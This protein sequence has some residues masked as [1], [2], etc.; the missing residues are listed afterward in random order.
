MRQPFLLSLIQS[1][2]CWRPLMFDNL[3]IDDL[4][5]AFYGHP[6]FP[7]LLLLFWKDLLDFFIVFGFI[8]VVKVLDVN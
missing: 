6:P 4:F 1:T 2:R 8:A 5:I 7:Q 3:Q